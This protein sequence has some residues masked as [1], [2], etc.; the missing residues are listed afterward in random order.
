[1]KD[2][3]SILPAG[4]NPTGAFWFDDSPETSSQVLII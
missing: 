1:L 3:A 4:H 2:R